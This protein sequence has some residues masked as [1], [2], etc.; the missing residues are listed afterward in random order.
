MC[1][2][3]CLSRVP[4]EQ[5]PQS[6]PQSQ[7]DIRDPKY[8]KLLRHDGGLKALLRASTPT[9]PRRA[10]QVRSGLPRESLRC[11]THAPGL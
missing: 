4:Q 11:G 5:P 3:N 7:V 2:P 6:Q 9:P 8:A 1:D 10:A